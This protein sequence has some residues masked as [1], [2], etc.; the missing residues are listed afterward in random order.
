MEFKNAAEEYSRKLNDDETTIYSFYEF[1]KKKLITKNDLV[2]TVGHYNLVD[3][4]GLE[5][6]NDV[7]KQLDKQKNNIWSNT[8]R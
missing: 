8:S 1:L 7:I 6:S 4:Y 3:N 2:T 5:N